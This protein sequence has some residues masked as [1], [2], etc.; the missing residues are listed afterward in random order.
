MARLFF[1]R[2]FNFHSCL[3]FIWILRCVFTYQNHQIKS[4]PASLQAKNLQVQGQILKID[5]ASGL[6]YGFDFLVE[7]C[8][9][10]NRPCAW[11]LPAKVRLYW[12]SSDHQN[13]QPDILPGQIWNF[14]LRLKRPHDLQNPGS[15][16]SIEKTFFEQNV[17]AKGYVYSKYQAEYL[18]YSNWDL[19]ATIEA[20]RFELWQYLQS[21]IPANAR[22]RILIAILLGYRQD[23]LDDQRLILSRTGTAHLMAISGLHV[24]IVAGLGFW[25]LQWLL[26]LF[27]FRLGK[28]G[29]NSLKIASFLSI[30]LVWVYTGFSGFGLPAQR[31][32]IMLSLGFAVHGWGAYYASR[33]IYVLAWYLVLIIQPFAFLNMGFWLSFIAVGVLLFGLRARLKTYSVFKAQYLAFVGLLPLSTL[34]FGQISWISP[35]ANLI[36]IPWFSVFIAPLAFLALLVSCVFPQCS[37]PLWIS[38]EENLK[39]LWEFLSYLSEHYANAVWDLPEVSGFFCLGLILS[40]GILLFPRGIYPKYWAILVL[41][42]LFSGLLESP[43]FSKNANLAA[44]EFKFWVLD[45]GQGLACVIETQHHRLL[46]DTGPKSAGM[47]LKNFMKAQGIQKI[48]AAILS[49]GDSDHTGALLKIVKEPWLEA[50]TLSLSAEPERT[51]YFWTQA[52]QYGQAWE[53]EGVKF[54]I[55]HPYGLTKKK[56]NDHSCVLKISN[57]NKSILLTGDIESKTEKKLVN[58]LGSDLKANIMVAPHHGSK[59][60]SSIEFLK[61]VRPDHV[62]FSSGHLN[63]WN[64]PNQVIISRYKDF[65]AL[66][67]NTAWDGAIEGLVAGEHLALKSQKQKKEQKPRWYYLW[68]KI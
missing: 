25:I 18:G 59:S 4:L 33:L 41:L 44:G 42:P 36:A 9:F 27:T 61:A 39:I 3:I 38:A 67:W 62:I 46:Y 40:A 19:F 48:D 28:I 26:S 68:S 15:N 51:A 50:R 34:F 22:G 58:I 53:W 8:K 66:I 30:V 35:L 43:K 5:S 64:M 21:L 7:A 1:F 32:A 49:H 65:G 20:K 14:M 23:F 10:E 13:H 57:Q 2:V 54:Q 63:Q 16:Y 12:A 6:N 56:S 29:E 17:V 24:G 55:L 52:C 11:S 31:A 37:R 47:V 45:V 60:S